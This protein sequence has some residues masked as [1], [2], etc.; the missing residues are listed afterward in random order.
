MMTIEL[1]IGILGWCSVINVGILLFW[2][3]ML[4]LAHD[5][6][7]RVHSCFIKISVEQFNTIHYAGIAFFKIC[8]IMFNL[9][10][11]LALRLLV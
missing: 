9:V 5:F 11:Y 7:F 8:I 3:L 6:V 1:L 10:P 4:T 2:V